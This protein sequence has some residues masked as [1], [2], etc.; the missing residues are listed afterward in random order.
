[1]IKELVEAARKVEMEMLQKHGVCEKVPIEES[2]ESPGKAPV[3]V[4]WVDAKKGDKGKPEYRCRLVAKE[5][6]K[7][8]G[9]TCLRRHRRWRRRRC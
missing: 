3:G 8:S 2:W 7:D 9:K 5:I 6:K 1:M 4:K